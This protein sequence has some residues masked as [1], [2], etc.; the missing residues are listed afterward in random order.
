MPK[1]P[2]LGSAGSRRGIQIF[3][4]I[5]DFAFNPYNQRTGS[6]PDQAFGM[7]N[8]LEKEKLGTKR[9]NRRWLE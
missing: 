4:D 6:E 8:R 7:E 5:E 9:T 3:P 2:Q 1:F